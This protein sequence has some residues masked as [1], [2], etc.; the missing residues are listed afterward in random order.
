MQYLGF[1]TDSPPFDDVRVRRAVAQAIDRQA[2][3][4]SAFLGT[5]PIANRLMPVPLRV[6]SKEEN[7]IDILYSPAEARASL[8]ALG[9]EPVKGFFTYNSGLGHDAWVGQLIEQI[10]SNLGWSIEARPLEWVEFLQW[11]RSADSLFRMTWAVDFPTSDNFLVPLL[12]SSSINT[13][14]F[15]GFASVEFDDCIQLARATA[16]ANLR[17]LRYDAAE[18]IACTQ[19]PVFPL[20]FGVQYHLIALDKFDVVEPAVDLFGEPTLRGFSSRHG[21]S[22]AVP[23]PR[24]AL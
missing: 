21:T 18:R 14:N 22:E 2:I 12:H 8:E 24:V 20:W 23:G 4:D 5:R 9:I 10:N 11:V 6:G 19:L 16:D 7:F 15:S 3:L 17:S 1:P 13:D